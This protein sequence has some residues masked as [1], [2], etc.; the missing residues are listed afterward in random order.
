MRKQTIHPVFVFLILAAFLG[1]LLFGI[2]KYRH[3]FVQSNADLVQFLP[4]DPGRTTAFVDLDLLRRTHYLDLIT[5]PNAPLDAD[6]RR[7]VQETGLDFTQ[8]VDAI[9][10]TFRAGQIDALAKGRFD[11]SRLRA[12]AVHHGGSCNAATV[13]SLPASTPGRAIAFAE[14]QP[15]VLRLETSGSADAPQ[16]LA[17][18]PVPG[19]M[20]VPASPVWLRPSREI[21]QFP[22]ALPLP[23]RSVAIVLQSATSV[24]LTLDRSTQGAGLVLTLTAHFEN[25][26]MA[27]TAKTQLATGTELLKRELGREKAPVSTADLTGLITS[28]SFTTARS[29]LVATWPIRPELLNSLR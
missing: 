6:Y 15:D 29:T 5:G 27:D 10:A 3:R 23:L 13:C 14:L 19:N 12:Y 25:N 28:G 7:F 16:A 4:T 1:A 26:A 17:A 22:N 2:Y 21:L 8:S 18:K 24:L 9:A 20:I 11:W